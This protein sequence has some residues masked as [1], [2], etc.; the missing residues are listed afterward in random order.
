MVKK[1]GWLVLILFLLTGCTIFSP[2]KTEKIDTYTLTATPAPISKKPPREITI[3]V[4]QPESNPIY[5]TTEM[6]Y[7]TK[8]F[9]VAYF[10]KSNWV[11]PPVMMLQPLIIKT[12]QNTHYFD[13]VLSGLSSAS[14]NYI[15]N[16]Q[17]LKLQ[18]EFTAHSSWIALNV[19]AQIIDVSENK[20]VATKNFSVTERVSVHTPY[21]GV[22]AANRAVSKMLN[23]LA[24]FCL[25]LE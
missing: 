17:L 10:A 12:L 1:N 22:M 3:M 14:Y 9:E 6:A 21:G 7:S 13:A 16:T 19:R 20:I 15:L 4:A 2:V 24:N 8:P 25:E 18:Q 5:N 11:Q 23:Q